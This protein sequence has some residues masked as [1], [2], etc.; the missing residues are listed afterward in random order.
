MN[1]EIHPLNTSDSWFHDDSLYLDFHKAI[2]KRLRRM[3]QED[4]MKRVISIKNLEQL[5]LILETLLEGKSVSN[6]FSIL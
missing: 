1:T 2:R 4:F 5:D 6:L 3:G